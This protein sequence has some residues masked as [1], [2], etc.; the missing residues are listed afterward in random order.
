LFDILLIFMFDRLGRRDDETPFIVQWFVAQGIEVWSVK[1]GQQRFDNHVD[2]LLNYIRFWQASGESEKTSIRIKTRHAQM[3]KE[4]LYRGGNP[5]FGY[6]LEPNGKFNKKGNPLNDMKIDPL[7][8]QV[9]RDIFTKTCHEG[10]GTHRLANYLNE[11][12]HDPG[13]MWRATTINRIICNSVYTG[14]VHFHDEVLKSDETLRIVDDSLFE[15]ANF[16]LHQRATANSSKRTVPQQTNGVRLLTGL[17]YCNHCGERLVGTVAREKRILKKTGE[18]RVKERPIY[19][20][21]GK[22]IHARNCG[23]QSLYSAAKI[24]ESVLTVVHSVF[25]KIHDMPFSEIASKLHAQKHQGVTARLDG[26]KN[27]KAR[28]ERQKNHLRE[29]LLKSINGE[30]SVDKELLSSFLMETQNSL[31]QISTQIEEAENVKKE[32]A[33]ESASFQQAY[34]TFLGWESEFSFANTQVRKMILANI[35]E[36][37]TVD[38]HY[39]ISIK[40]HLTT[41]QFI[42]GF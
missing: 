8:L 18:L 10:Y 25:L 19:R 13:K 20:C 15:R 33:S 41:K 11:A 27:E 30:K 37:I 2:K 16:I 1:E 5:P 24:E 3:V 32:S 38:R 9:V 39:N 4:G 21:Y 14:R 36:R 6:R 31:Q 23:G 12:Y 34:S 17:L 7:T 35:I 28:L 22:D 42:E 29:E 40:L 26:L